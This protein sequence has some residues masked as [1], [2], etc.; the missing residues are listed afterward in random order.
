M[1]VF[2]VSGALPMYRMAALADVALQGLVVG[3]GRLESTSN[4]TPSGSPSRRGGEAER[5][6]AHHPLDP[7][8]D[9]IEIF[10]STFFSY[11]ED[12]D[13]AYRLRASGWGAY[14]V[15]AARAW[16]DR[17]AGVHRTRRQRS[18]FERRLSWRNH[19]LMLIAN[20]HPRTFARDWWRIIGYELGKLAYIL[21]CEPGTLRAIPQLLHLLPA[22]L[23]KRKRVMETYRATPDA[24]HHWYG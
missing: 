1:G 14:C 2:G 17:T 10:D 16:H 21:A 23:R 7:L 19:L 4:P 22:A 15:P 24:M 6:S 11:K 8:S 3:G 13:L 18:V 12:V 9:P 20:E 5:V